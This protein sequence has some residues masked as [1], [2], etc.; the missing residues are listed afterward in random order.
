MLSKVG[1]NDTLL[2]ILA[3]EFH[4]RIMG[5][6]QKQ[7][8]GNLEPRHDQDRLGNSPP[9]HGDVQNR[10]MTEKEG[11]GSSLESAV[12][13]NNSQKSESSGDGKS[14][15]RKSPQSKTGSNRMV[16]RSLILSEYLAGRRPSEAVENVRARSTRKNLGYDT[17]RAWYKKFDEGLFRLIF[18][19]YDEED[20][21]TKPGQMF[22]LDRS[23]A[24][25]RKIHS[26]LLGSWLST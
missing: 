1:K 24:T 25:L 11:S 7:F 16:V 10:K 26:A 12:S 5:N 4:T 3:R 22:V 2:P 19:S 15:H 18:R 8:P 13:S 23:R 21:P 6:N 14:K 9:V 17:V 20:A